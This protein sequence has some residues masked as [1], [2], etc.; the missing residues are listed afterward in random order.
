MGAIGFLLE[1]VKSDGDP[2]QH[3]RQRVNGYIQRLKFLQVH[4]RGEDFHGVHGAQAIG[5][6]S[7]AEIRGVASVNTPQLY[8][9]V[10]HEHPAH[11]VEG[12]RGG[13][14]PPLSHIGASETTIDHITLTK[15]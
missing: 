7:P 14:Y 10:Y 9:R 6:P 2:V 3:L 15:S 1:E 11:F 13:R 12:Q 4:A 8:R 5:L